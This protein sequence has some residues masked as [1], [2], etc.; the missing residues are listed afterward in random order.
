M[1]HVI[2]HGVSMSSF[3]TLY[4]KQMPHT[5]FLSSGWQMG[6]MILKEGR[7]F[8]PSSDLLPPLF[9]LTTMLLSWACAP[10]C[11]W[12]YCIAVLYLS[13]WPLFPLLL[14]LEGVT[15]RPLNWVVK[16]ASLVTERLTD[17]SSS[18]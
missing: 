6:N 7:F 8:L 9:T 10:A 14:V 1:D 11:K 13:I 5:F 17:S 12:I 18:F 16:A 4:T 15:L 3:I 2:T